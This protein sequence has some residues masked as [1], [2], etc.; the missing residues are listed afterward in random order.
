MSDSRK[1]WIER[2]FDE[3]FVLFIKS[4]V[5]TYND[6][7]DRNNDDINN[8]LNCIYPVVRDTEWECN[9]KWDDRE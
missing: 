6:G 5:N 2:V 7:K 4:I 9:Y 3:Y 8:K 1:N